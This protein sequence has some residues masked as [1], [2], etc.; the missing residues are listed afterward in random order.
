MPP[1]STL[2]RDPLRSSTRLRDRTGEAAL[3]CRRWQSH[4]KDTTISFLHSLRPNLRPLHP[5]LAWYP[6]RRR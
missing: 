2:P 5:Y 1:F 4:S 6:Q 3:A